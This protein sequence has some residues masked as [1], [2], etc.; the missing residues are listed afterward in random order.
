MQDTDAIG[1]LIVIEDHPLLRAALA[2]ALRTEGFVVHASGDVQ[3]A[4]GLLAARPAIAA[5]VLEIDLGADRPDGF[6][7][8]E[9]ARAMR[10]DIGIV[11]LT[12]RMDLLVGR[13]PDPTEIHLVK[14]V[15]VSRIAGAVR[16]V[17]DASRPATGR[18]D[19]T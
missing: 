12:G 16:K 6:D 15:A 1:E 19:P 3:A 2:L 18:T 4:L 13:R 9:A 10:P 7:F 8:V 11:F 17:I 5:A 14:P